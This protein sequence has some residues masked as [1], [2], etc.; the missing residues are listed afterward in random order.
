MFKI[1][2]KNIAWGEMSQEAITVTYLVLTFRSAIVLECL[3][4]CGSA[5]GCDKLDA[6]HSGVLECDDVTRSR[7]KKEVTPHAHTVRPPRSYPL[8][9]A[10]GELVDLSERVC[11]DEVRAVCRHS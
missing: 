3:Q 10:L 7:R 6:V 2:Q 1:N 11:T 5:L 8:G 9:M 4:R